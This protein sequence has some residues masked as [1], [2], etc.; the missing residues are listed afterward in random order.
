[1]KRIPQKKSIINLLYKYRKFLL[2]LALF[3]FSFSLRAHD[4]NNDYPFGWD[5]VDNAWTAKNI[6][7]NHKFPLVGMVAKQNTGFFIGP[8]YYYFISFFYYLTNLN[9]IALQYVALTTS[10]FTFFVIFFI[11]KKLFNFKV[12]IIACFINSVSFLGYLFDTVQWPVAFLPGISLIIFYFLLKVLKGNIK[13]ILPLAAISGFAFH[14]HFT[15]IFFPIIIVL[16]LPFFP[17]NKKTFYYLLLSIP[18]FLVWFIPNLIY[19]FQHSSQLSNLSNYL[20]VYYHGFHLKRF[21]QLT[22]DGLIQFDPYLYFQALKPL[23]ILVIP[24]FLFVFLRKS[25]SRDKMV[26]S[27]LV[28]VF[29]LVPWL[30]FST[31]KGEISDYYFSINRFIVLFILS[32]LIFKLFSFK[33]MI[34]KITVLGFLIYY[35]YLNLNSILHYDDG[36]GLRERFEKVKPYV[37]SNHRI[38]FQ[39]GA[40]ESYIYYYFMK[41]KGVEVY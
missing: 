14:I 10:V 29:F 30:V 31:Y 4:M 6:I 39:E 25:I 1:M 40:A 2:I 34:I 11:T 9:P 17:R 23:K 32:Y 16:C 19:Q 33:N 26:F 13:Y 38:E 27:Y 8:I 37:E 21:L 28:L 18:L 36:G 5:Q 20:S 24:L 3:I 22:R 41:Q 35:S 12:A 15:A 7:I